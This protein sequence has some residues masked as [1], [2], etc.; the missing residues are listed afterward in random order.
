MATRSR[1]RTEAESGRMGVRTIASDA[2]VLVRTRNSSELAQTSAIGTEMLFPVNP[3]HT[4][5]TTFPITG[6]VET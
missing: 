2:P 1:G 6:A 3:L 4:A 5:G